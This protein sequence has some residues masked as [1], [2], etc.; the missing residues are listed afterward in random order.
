VII[1]IDTLKLRE[2]GKD[3]LL[4]ANEFK[5]K[6]ISI[7]NK[8]LNMEANGE[9]VGSSAKQFVNNTNSDKEQ[10]SKLADALIEYG[11]FMNNAATKVEDL[12]R[13]IRR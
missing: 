9:W 11:N 10:Y 8:I 6:N 5:S 2:N 7:F 12:C 3:F 13:E 4:N 1:N